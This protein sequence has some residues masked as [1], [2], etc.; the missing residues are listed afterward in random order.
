MKK[1][2]YEQHDRDSDLVVALANHFEGRFE[3]RH[4]GLITTISNLR[5]NSFDADNHN[6]GMVA[7]IGNIPFL[8]LLIRNDRLTIKCAM[9]LEQYTPPIR[10][11]IPLD[12]HR[13]RGAKAKA[14][15]SSN[16]HAMP[17]IRLDTV[18]FLYELPDCIQL[19]EYFVDKIISTVRRR[20][21]VQRHS[22]YLKEDADETNLIEFAKEQ[23]E[24]NQPRLKRQWQRKLMKASQ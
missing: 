10:H 8:Y 4:R 22:V 18:D 5:I 3:K 12:K 24:K 9:P 7:G 20:I 13:K 17:V 1:Y 6:P 11:N 16:V 19:A 2:G 15:L 21:F 23:W 14:T